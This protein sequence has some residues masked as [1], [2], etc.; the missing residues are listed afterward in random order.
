MNGLLYVK[1]KIRELNVFKLSTEKQ[2]AQH[3]TAK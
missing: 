1:K 3:K 2:E